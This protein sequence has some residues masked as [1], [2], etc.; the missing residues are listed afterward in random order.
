MP[1]PKNPVPRYSHHKPSGRAYVRLPHGTGGRKTVYLGPYDS[2]ESRAEYARL[3]AELLTA[4]PPVTPGAGGQSV[5]VNEVLLAFMRH[6]DR[7]YRRS[8]GTATNEL[9]QYRQTFRL[10]K[11]L[12]GATAAGE[13]GPRSLKILR[14]RMIDIGWSRK[15]IN[16]RVGRVRRAFKHAASEELIPVTVYQALT[17]VTGL[18]VGRTEARETDPVLPVAEEAVRATLPFL[19]PALRAMVRV[20]LLTGMRPGEVC[21]LRPRD[22]DAT[23]AVWL[24]R[25]PQ[26]KTLH[27]NKPRV[28]AIGPRAQE[29]LAA[30]TP[31]EPTDYY[32]SPRRV[33]EGLH[34]ERSAKRRTP[35]YRSHMERNAAQRVA[36]P[37]REPAAGYTVVSFGRAVR[38]A[39][40]RANARRQRL[41]GAGNFDAVPHWHPNQLRHAHATAVRHRYGLEAA[42]VALGHE[43]ADVTQVY[44]ERNVALAVTVAAEMG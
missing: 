32:F 25:P 24:Y 4:P 28:V 34:A 30:F 10:V 5:T 23:G 17:T 21:Q 9:A 12:F 3:V 14:G 13:F 40:E 19:Q 18:Q 26:H 35:R 1:R 37:K 33:V 27:R 44:A 31:A 39:V 8:D 42:Q 43:R 29:L 15:L 7:H 11:E 2:P 38:R 41:A 16:Q 36:T 22:L 6:A 20:Q